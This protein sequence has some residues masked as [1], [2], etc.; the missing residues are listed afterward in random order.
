MHECIAKI[1]RLRK[2]YEI[3]TVAMAPPEGKKSTHR[4]IM[5]SRWLLS[6][7]ILDQNLLVPFFNRLH[8]SV[9]NYKGKGM[10]MI[11]RSEKLKKR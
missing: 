9:K 10:T 5:S 11:A 4:L 6:V 1:D 3:I 2:R 7:K 8:K